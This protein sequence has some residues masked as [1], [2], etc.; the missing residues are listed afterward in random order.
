MS[1]HERTKKLKEV[2]SMSIKRIEHGT[3]EQK[4]LLNIT[5]V[6]IYTGLGTSAARTMMD[7]IGATVKYGARVLFDKKVIDAA[8]D[9][10]RA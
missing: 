1:I 10:M 2:S 9:Q 3:I 7:E 4:R 6:Q 5:E 8:I